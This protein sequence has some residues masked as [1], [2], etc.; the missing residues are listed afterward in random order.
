M[1]NPLTRRR[2]LLLRKWTR[3]VE[4]IYSELVHLADNRQ[5]FRD[6]QAVVKNNRAIN[7]ENAFWEFILTSYTTYASLAVRRQLDRDR[8]SVSFRLLLEDILNHPQALTRRRLL[9][10][11]TRYGMPRKHANDI[12][13]KSKRM[14]PVHI[15]RRAVMNDLA[16]LERACGKIHRFVNKTAAHTNKRPLRALPTFSDLDKAIDCIESIFNHYLFL[17]RGNGVRRFTPV[18]AEDW[19]WI[20][21]VPWRLVRA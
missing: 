3:W 5:I 1:P 11:L 18:H 19:K 7:K 16:C 4:T 13:D 6:T 14:G 21:D 8:R 9:S 2:S 17:V 15:S 12:I 10:S 20:F